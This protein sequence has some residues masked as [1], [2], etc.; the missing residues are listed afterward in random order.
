MK[1]FVVL[2]L[3]AM[4]VFMAACS[5]TPV[6]APAVETT[7]A[8]QPAAAKMPVIGVAIFDYSNNYVT[9]IRNSIMAVSA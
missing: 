8:T 2:L 6:Q 3:V 1:K 7:G 4:L 5:A 9:Y